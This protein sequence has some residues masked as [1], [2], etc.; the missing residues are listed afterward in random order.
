VAKAELTSAAFSNAQHPKAFRQD[1]LNIART[2]LSSKILTADKVRAA[3]SRKLYLV[4]M[5]ECVLNS[6]CKQVAGHVAT[7]CACRWLDLRAHSPQYCRSAQAADPSDLHH[8]RCCVVHGAALLLCC[9]CAE[10]GRFAELAVEAMSQL[11]I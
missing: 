9:S 2:T 8:S 10:Q 1:L 11:Q 5:A 4:V 7:L 3:V 6:A